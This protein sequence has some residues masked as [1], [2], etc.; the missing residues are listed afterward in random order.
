MAQKMASKWK[1]LAVKKEMVT[2]LK[3]KVELDSGMSPRRVVPRG[4]RR[5]A[6]PGQ[7]VVLARKRG[8]L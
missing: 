2:M 8:M 4:E 1:V 3:R 5:G 6:G 7:F